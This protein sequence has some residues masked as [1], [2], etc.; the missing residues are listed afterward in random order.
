[1]TTLL[2]D[3]INKLQKLPDA[4]QNHFANRVLSEVQWQES[5][6]QSK[7]KLDSLENC[8]LEEIQNGKFKKIDC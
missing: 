3:A 5:F 4:D 6:Q 1:M 8:L 2:E 7:D